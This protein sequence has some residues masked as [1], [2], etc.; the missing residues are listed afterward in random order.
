MDLATQERILE[1]VNVDRSGLTVL[2]GA[3]DPESAELSAL[4]VISGDPT[5]AGPLA[6]VQLGLPVYHILETAVEAA[7]DDAAYEEHASLMKVALDLEAIGE[8]MA[9]VRSGAS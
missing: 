4:T 8:T 9:R 7:S 5:Y 6:G 3:P 1:L 2:L